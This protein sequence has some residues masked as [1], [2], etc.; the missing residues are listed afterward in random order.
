MPTSTTY[1]RNAHLAYHGKTVFAEVNLTLT[2]GKWLA[3]L[4]QSGVGK[5]SLL[6]LIAG[7]I[8]KDRNTKGSLEIETSYP[9]PFSNHIAYM[10]QTDMLLPWLTVFENATLQ[11]KLRKQT[12]DQINDIH[13][14]ATEWLGKVGLTDSRH[15]YPH[16]LSGGMRQRVALVRTFLEN[17]PIILMDEP[18][19]ALDAITRYQLQALA[20]DLLRHK[21]VIMITHDPLEALRLA[22]DIFIMQK[23]VPGLKQVANLKS[24]T[25]RE[26]TETGFAEHQ[27]MLFAELAKAGGELC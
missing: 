6:K 4:G 27:A 13:R 11:L 1:L 26:L 2:P 10:A 21:T 3:L 19:S 18:F 9:Q 15:A 16:A 25:P 23:G 24:P 8:K 17:K 20:A 7:L 22:D 14:L 12:K 5:S